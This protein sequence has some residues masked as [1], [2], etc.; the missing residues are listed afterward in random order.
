MPYAKQT[1]VLAKGWVEKTL[2]LKPGQELFI[3]CDNKSQQISL[4]TALY[5][6]RKEYSAV[7]P[8]AAESI[9]FS[10]VWRENL[11]Y[12][13]C[14]KRQFRADVG[15]IKNPDDSVE[16]VTITVEKDRTRKIL[17]MIKDGKTQA[18]VD[19]VFKG[20]S[21]DEKMLFKIQPKKEVKNESK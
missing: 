18:E 20:L 12:V 13:K 19:E 10:P 5:G 9:S 4:K 17:M 3:P 16:E 14:Y 8:V 21:D 1:S 7:D 11:P 15:F 2:A 6:A